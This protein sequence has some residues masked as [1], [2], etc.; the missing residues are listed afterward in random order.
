MIADKDLNSGFEGIAPRR[1]CL[2]YL[3]LLK[4]SLLHFFWLTLCSEWKQKL[5]LYLFLSKI[6]LRIRTLLDRTISGFPQK[7]V[8]LPILVQLRLVVY[9]SLLSSFQTTFKK[10]KKEKPTITFPLSHLNKNSHSSV[11]PPLQ[12]KLISTNRLLNV[13]KS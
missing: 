11:Q 8:G 9:D 7:P 12:K 13:Q 4:S 5:D 3:M 6:F 10:K 1:I 2:F